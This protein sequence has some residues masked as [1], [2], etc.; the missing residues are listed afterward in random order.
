MIK[1][2]AFSLQRGCGMEALTKTPLMEAKIRVPSSLEV[3]S[4]DRLNRLLDHGALAKL[5]LVVGPAGYGK[6]V[7]LSSYAA[8]ARWKFCWYS[9]DREDGDPAVFLTYLVESLRRSCPDIGLDTLRMLDVTARSGAGI[10][11]AIRSLCRELETYLTE[12]LTIV[13]DD[14]HTVQG[15]KDIVE[16]LDYLIRFSPEGLRL[17]VLSRQEVPLSVERLQLEGRLFRLGPKELELTLPEFEDLLKSKLPDSSEQGALEEFY[18]WSG[19]WMAPAVLLGR[20][21]R[22]RHGYQGPDPSARLLA[23]DHLFSYVAREIYEAFR[24]ELKRFARRVAVLEVLNPESARALTGCPEVA[25]LIRELQDRLVLERVGGSFRFHPLTREF[26]LE[27]LGAEEDPAAVAEVHSRAG[28]ILEAGGQK[29][30]AVDHFLKAGMNSEATAVAREAVISMF[31]EGHL[32]SAMDLLNSV[33][34]EL[35]RTDHWLCLHYGRVFMLQGDHRQGKVYFDLA[36]NLARE[37]DDRGCLVDACI[38]LADLWNQRHQGDQG[39]RE[40]EAAVELADDQRRPLAMWTLA[41]CYLAQGIFAEARTWYSRSLE[42]AKETGDIMTQ[43]MA[44]SG[45][46]VMGSVTGDMRET[47]SLLRESQNLRRKLLR[48]PHEVTEP[49]L[50]LTWIRLQ[51]GEMTEIPRMLLECREALRLSR[52]YPNRRHEGWNL[53]ALAAVEAA[54]LDFE[55][56]KRDAQESLAILEEIHDYLVLPSAM[57]VLGTI[58]VAQGDISDGIE[59]Y[60]RSAELQKSHHNYFWLGRTL[61]DLANACALGGDLQRCAEVLP[62]AET[63][64]KELDS[65]LVLAGVHLLHSRIRFAEGRREEALAQLRSCLRLTRSS[66][67]VGG[68]SSWATPDGPML[69][70]AF[71]RMAADGDRADLVCLSDIAD[72][73][74]PASRR[75]FLADLALNRSPKVIDEATRLFGEMPPALSIGAAVEPTMR[76]FLLGPFQLYI[77]GRL[78]NAGDWRNKKARSLLQYLLVNVGRAVTR[79]ELIAVFWP[80]S[81]PGAG[82]KLFYRALKNIREELDPEYSPGA[83]HKVILTR[84]SCYLIDPDIP[85]WVDLHEFRRGIDVAR[86]LQ[87][88]GENSKA[89]TQLEEAA[90][91]Y[92]GDLSVSSRDGEWAAQECEYLRGEYRGC[93][94]RLARLEADVGEFE[95]AVAHGEKLVAMDP[96]YEDFQRFMIRIFLKMDQPARAARQYQMLR[97]VLSRELGVDPSPETVALLEQMRS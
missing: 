75:Q 7:L 78:I 26:L 70:W 44:M 53:L 96:C 89:V 11:P 3:I 5:L 38:A 91:L 16:G 93:L 32:Q 13:L 77:G 34:G 2:S 86:R 4:R 1:P 90:T 31:D 40:V 12:H 51:R 52:E 66:G 67:C 59:I 57:D 69:A 80:E 15:Q 71:G 83:S 55:S 82:A 84:G 74:A 94:E 10:A 35:I 25:D 95:M 65:K 42:S 45:L 46:A 41:D 85:L 56:A 23:R 29:R 64:G 81:S 68:V 49:H 39:V 30:K 43:A 28:K 72:H 73:L 8:V 6:T 22:P 19:G 61:V 88:A 36:K 87:S 37:R 9:L 17:A 27:Q 58:A 60:R 48:R 62:E 63:L 92:R 50:L 21:L 18:R 24:G 79:D 20:N 76:A 97:R 33:P 47:E 54:L 14:F